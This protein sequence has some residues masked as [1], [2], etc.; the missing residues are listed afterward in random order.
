M[1]AGR[2]AFAERVSSRAQSWRLLKHQSETLEY[3]MHGV[4]TRRGLLIFN[5]RREDTPLAAYAALAWLVWNGLVVK[6]PGGNSLLCFNY[7]FVIAFV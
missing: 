4:G 6:L 3:S 1:L 5:A 2:V 7:K